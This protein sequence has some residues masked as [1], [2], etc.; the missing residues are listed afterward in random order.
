[1]WYEGSRLRVEF[2]EEGLEVNR[3]SMAKLVKKPL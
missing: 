2:P 3:C 1:L